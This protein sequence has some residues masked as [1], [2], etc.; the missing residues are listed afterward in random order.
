MST[1]SPQQSTPSGADP[2]K[3]EAKA[4]PPQP[5]PAPSTPGASDEHPTLKD[6]LL[7]RAKDVEDP[8]VFH[9]ISLVAFLAW[10]GLGADGLSSS[11]YG[12]E[13]AFKALGQHTFL[14]LGMALAMGFTVV[15]ISASYSQIIE[16]FPY[17]GGGYMV[18]SK[19][20]G[21][22]VGVVSG[23]ALLIDYVLTIT[24]SIAAGTEA[25]FSFL[26]PS[27]ASWK[28]AVDI[29]AIAVLT[30]L[31]LRGVKE[32]V[33]VLLP[34]FLGFLVTHAI[35]IFGVLISRAYEIPEIAHEV[36]TGYQTGVAALGGF[37][38]LALFLRAYSMGA[39]TYTGIEAVSNGL[40]IMREPKVLTGKR[41]MLLM[42]VSLTVTAGGII[43]AYLLMHVSPVEGKTMNAV[44]AERFANGWAPFGLRVGS[45]FVLATLAFEALLLFVAALSGFIAGP[46]V[47]ANMAVDSFLPHR[48]AQLSDRLTMQNGVLLMGT[49]SLL[50]LLYTGG[51]VTHL[52]IMYSINVF[53]TFSLSQAGMIRFWL[54][55]K[56]RQPLW[57]RKLSIHVVA[58]VLCLFIL[59]VTVYEKFLQGGWVTLALTSGLIA[60][61]FVIR[62]HYRKV[63]VNL[64]RLDAIKEA[65]P[66]DEREPRPL[67]PK[68]PT[69]VLLVGSYAGLGIHSLLNI[70]RLFAGHFYN[71]VFISVGVIDTAT[72][73]DL[74]EVNEVRDRTRSSLEQYVA[75]ARRLGL[76]AE[77]RM[78]VGTDAIDEAQS[79]CRGLVKQ[80][81]RCVF[82][83][84]KLVFERERWFQRV[85]H[86]ETAYQ[87]QRRLQFAG[88]D[89]MVLPVRI[90]GV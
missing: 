14:A 32:S 34:I 88:L 59:A 62:R 70:Q 67:D 84:G 49:A 74:D 78:A 18:A 61:C 83:A 19:L 26:P 38:V 89:A 45:F 68:K 81:P 73:T 9:H 2:A 50:A 75:L 63:V 44:L 60:L 35:L 16:H 20:L 76:P 39:G 12:P 65:L 79:L 85:L 58:L 41:T 8:S 82:F 87:L 57:R 22:G 66:R 15:I 72:F 86:N 21:R 24:V 56:Q 55:Q 51:N 1:E 54:R 47:M 40:A 13:E 90:M 33:K 31:N 80:F 17:G 36:R 10:V 7:G 48:F 27:A 11:S 4:E 5:A 29:L 71:F 46:R 43:V 23:S 30:T 25:I 64:R 3:T 77:Y 6:L 52:V 53:V 28:M 69:A 42:A 37:G